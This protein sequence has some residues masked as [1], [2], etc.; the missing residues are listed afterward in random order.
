MT[1]ADAIW[2]RELLFAL[3]RPQAVPLVDYPGCPVCRAKSNSAKVAGAQPC[4]DTTPDPDVEV[5]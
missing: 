2:L 3:L 1:T 5:L 4:N